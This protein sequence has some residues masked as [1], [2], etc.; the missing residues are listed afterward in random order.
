MTLKLRYPSG[1]CK[2]FMDFHSPEVHEQFAADVRRDINTIAA[3]L[4][5]LKMVES[6][7]LRCAAKLRS[8]SKEAGNGSHRDK[9]ATVI[10]PPNELK[11]ALKHDAAK[12]ALQAIGKPSRV[13]AIVNALRAAG[14]GATM[15]NFNNAIYTA[16]ARK[17][18]TFKKIGKDWALKEWNQRATPDTSSEG[19]E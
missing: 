14:Y 16:M 11:G 2:D 17:K 12:L 8:G 13:P 3:E 18:D 4:E 9:D 19:D 5:Q 7:H 15:K 6:W 10:I 1:S